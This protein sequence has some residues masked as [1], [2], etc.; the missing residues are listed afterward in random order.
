MLAP[1]LFQAPSDPQLWPHFVAELSAWRARARR[2]LNYR[3]TLYQRADFAWVSGNYACYF[4][5]LGDQRFYDRQA[6]RFRVQEWLESGRRE[7]GGYDSVVLWHAYPRIG[8][9]E[10]NQFD[11]YRDM[12]GGL[13]GLRHTVDELHRAGLRVFINYNPWDERTRREPKDDVTMIAEMVGEL[14][15][16]GVF[17]DT[18]K[19]GAAD[20]R[21]KLDAVRPGVVLESEMSLPL[22]RITD[23]HMSWAQ[24]FEDSAVPGIVRNKWF[25]RRHQ[26]HHVARWEPDRTHLAQTAFMNGTGLMIWDNIFGTWNGYSPREKSILRSML[27]I[28]RRFSALFSGEGWTPLVPT[29]HPQSFANLWDC[30]GIR[31]WTLVNRT[32]GEVLTGLPDLTAEPGEQVWDLIRGCEVSRPQTLIRPRGVGC[33]LAA[34]RDRLGEDF[35]TFL[36]RQRAT[37]E[38]ADWSADVPAD[39]E[40]RLRLTPRTTPY[41]LE[42]LPPDMVSIPGGH[43]RSA[44]EF[45]VRECGWYESTRDK[46]PNFFPHHQPAHREF[47]VVLAP[48]AMD[49]TPVTNRQYAAFLHAS[50]YLPVHAQNFLKHWLNGAPPAG[51]EEHPVVYVDLEDARAYAR[52]ADKRLPT[53]EEWQL[54]AQGFEKRRYPWGETVPHPAAN[55]C[56]TSR[57]GT[58]SVRQFPLGGSPFGLFDL[59]GNTWS[60]TESERS[61]GVNRFAIIRGGCYHTLEGSK[62]YADS[63]VQGAAFGAKFMLTWPGLDR[64]ATIGFRC[65]VDVA[66]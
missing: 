61:D 18:L 51:L 27:P 4:L 56:N 22:E 6:G 1:H 32:A 47:D 66:P 17:L 29:L 24:D 46:I 62:W 35:D 33:L 38:C 59:C 49:L 23:H 45:Q 41:R 50:G 13:A 5:L 65:V 11:F 57:T 52:W 2:E 44:V 14:G 40:T 19:E 25:E 3:D 43:V 7:F 64:C 55:L 15:A 20:F 48:Y 36:A 34:R 37:D 42:N 63:G 39:V 21:A 10:R 12:P 9:D 16:D 60:W 31:L 26:L 54:A 30:A 8:F 28:Q 58:T 53:E